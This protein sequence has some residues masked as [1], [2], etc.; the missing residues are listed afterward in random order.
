MVYATSQAHLLK[1][2]REIAKTLVHHHR[3][4][5]QEFMNSRRPS[6]RLY[7]TG[8]YAFAKRSVKSIKKRGLVGKLMNSYTRPL[9]IIDKNMVLSL[10]NQIQALKYQL[11]VTIGKNRDVVQSSE[12]I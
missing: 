12:D 5:H 9:E 8:D 1:Y 4:Y 11:P 10:Q 3:S 6:P 2:G 7:S